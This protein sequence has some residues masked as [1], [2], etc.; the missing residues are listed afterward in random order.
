MCNK[1]A[2]RNNF[3]GLYNL[4]YALDPPMYEECKTRLVRLSIDI[5]LY[6]FSMFAMIL[7]NMLLLEQHLVLAYITSLSTLLTSWCILQFKFS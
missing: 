5:V 1:K 4:M 2:K 7:S 6:V 3:V